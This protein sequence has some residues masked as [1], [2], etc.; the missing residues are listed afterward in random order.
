MGYTWRE[1]LSLIM[2][3]SGRPLPADLQELVEILAE[4]TYNLRARQR[5]LS[6]N[7]GS[8]SVADDGHKRLDRGASPGFPPYEEL[9][10]SEKQD[11]RNSAIE[12]LK[13]IHSLGYRLEPATAPIADAGADI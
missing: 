4:N 13:L 8:E 9:P 6:D 12:T 11:D 10:D 2:E 7:R 5:L 3:N 1:N